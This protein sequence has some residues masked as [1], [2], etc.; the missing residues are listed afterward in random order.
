[1]VEGIHKRKIIPAAIFSTLDS[2]LILLDLD[3]I[4]PDEDSDGSDFRDFT[5]ET[6][7]KI[8]RYESIAGS[9]K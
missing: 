9:C 7:L 4:F 1:M 8:P 3:E 6:I 2:W 5:I